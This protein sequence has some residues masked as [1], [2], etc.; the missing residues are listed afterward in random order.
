MKIIA[1]IQSRMSS[2]RYPGKMLAPFLGKPLFFNVISQIRLSKLDP[3]II[4]A[5][6]NDITDDPL[7][8]YAKFLNIDVV[9]GPLDDVMSRF[10][11]T[12]DT[13]ES[14]A[15]FRVCGDSPLVPSFLFDRASYLYGSL[16][17]DIIT[18]IFPRTF[19]EGMSIELINSNVFKRYE[20]IINNKADR[21]HITQYFYNQKNKFKILNIECKKLIDRDLKLSLD[22]PEDLNRIEKWEKNRVKDLEILFPIN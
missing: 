13:Y 16:N 6:S 5:T 9:R 3:L 19:P 17:Y 4:L 8:E 15:F 18:N 10:I 20:K 2:K 11:M 7:V 21:E 12:L 22:T 1:I 14:E